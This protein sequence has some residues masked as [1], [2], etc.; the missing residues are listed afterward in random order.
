[1][2]REQ[3]D[4]RRGRWIRTWMLAMMMVMGLHS[5]VQQPARAI[6]VFDA[7]ALA[8]A[9]TEFADQ[10]YTWLEEK[11]RWIREE[12]YFETSEANQ[13]S[14]IWQQLESYYQDAEQWYDNHVA[15]SV[16]IVSGW[17][18]D[19]SEIYQKYNSLY[20]YY[21]KYIDNMFTSIEWVVDNYGDSDYWA[22][23]FSNGCSPFSKFYQMRKNSVNLRNRALALGKAIQ[24]ASIE[25]SETVDKI[26]EEAAS[27]QS[28]LAVAQAAVG[29]QA[30]IAELQRQ[31]NEL[32]S[33][34]LMLSADEQQRKVK[35]EQIQQLREDVMFQT[36]EFDFV[37]A[38]IDI[39]FFSK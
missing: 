21:N 8:E 9:I 34:M 5:L 12:L 11:D 31:N 14:Q 19:L 37:S 29:V 18:K 24:D 16:D 17:Y 23:C 26:V 10:T 6:A 33:E 38:P 3:S 28:D 7:S 15:A 20:S 27:T 4:G 25:S 2:T 35:E 39:S 1:M 32:M 36:T 30:Q 13:L 22:K